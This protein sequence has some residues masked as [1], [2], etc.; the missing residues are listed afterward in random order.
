MRVGK[1]ARW[2]RSS[3]GQ[4]PRIGQ[5][6]SDLI[7]SRPLDQEGQD[8]LGRGLGQHL[9]P[10]GECLGGLQPAQDPVTS[11]V[12]ARANQCSYGFPAV[13]NS[14]IVINSEA[15]ATAAPGIIRMNALG[16][17]A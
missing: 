9:G 8:T 1:H 4:A 12:T 13:A 2:P 5:A 6:A 17:A 16:G 10:A 11:A 3:I 7:V 14:V 15:A